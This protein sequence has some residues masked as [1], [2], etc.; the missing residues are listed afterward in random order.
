[1]PGRPFSIG[2][3]SRSAITTCAAQHLQAY[4]GRTCSSTIRLAGTY[5]SCSRTSSPI[6]RRSPPQLGAGAVFGGD[7][8]DDPL[9]GQARRQRLAAV[10]AWASGFGAAG[11]GG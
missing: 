10:A 2:S 11:S 3:G 8:V 6:G 4:F 5:S 1:M 9:A 7:V